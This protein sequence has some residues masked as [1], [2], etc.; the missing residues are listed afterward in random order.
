MKTDFPCCDQPRTSCTAQDIQDFT[1]RLEATWTEWADEAVTDQAQTA[2]TELR[3]LVAVIR[4]DR[5]PPHAA[6]VEA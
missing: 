2:V 4:S 3:N 1:D 6:T 5:T